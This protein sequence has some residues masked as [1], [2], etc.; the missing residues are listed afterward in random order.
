LLTGKQGQA[1]MPCRW[2]TALIAVV[3]LTVS[4]TVFGVI[5]GVVVCGL[6]LAL[7]NSFSQAATLL[8]P[9]AGS[10]LLACALIA[11]AIVVPVARNVFEVSHRIACDYPL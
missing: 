11:A 8:F 3:L 5:G 7:A 4:I 1:I 2:T 6:V 9:I 10:V